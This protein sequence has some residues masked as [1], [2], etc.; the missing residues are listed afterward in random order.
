MSEIDGSPDEIREWCA[1]V[2]REAARG[3]QELTFSIERALTF[4][5]HVAAAEL[6]EAKL[7]TALREIADRSCDDVQTGYASSIHDPECA[8]CR[9]RKELGP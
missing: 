9:A 5:R 6:R 8:R 4:T 1:F 2:G 7:R 3:T